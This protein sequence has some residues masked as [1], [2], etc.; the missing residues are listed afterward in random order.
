MDS[1]EIY[2]EK[3][4]DL[5]GDEFDDFCSSMNKVLLKGLRVNLSKISV[6]DFLNIF[7]YDISQVD[8][9]NEGFYIDDCDIK[10]GKTPLYY[11]GLFYLQEP[12]AMLPGV[13]LNVEEDDKILDI[14]AAPGGK[15]TQI[16]SKLGKKGLLVANDIS[17]KRSIALAKNLAYAGGENSIVLNKKPEHLAEMFLN[18]FD[19]ILI[20]APCS[21][22]GLFKK[23]NK[24][25]EDDNSKYASMQK[26]ILIEIPKMLKLDGE[27]VYSTCTFSPE[28]NEKI[29][30]WFLDKYPDFKLIDINIE[31]LSNGR[32]EWAENYRD[33]D[34]TKRAWPHKLK[35][36]GHF[37]ARLK[38]TGRDEE[39][40]KFKHISQL[41]EDEIII[42]E[43][44]VE[45][46]GIDISIY[47]D[48]YDRL[49]RIDDKLYLLPYA[50]NFKVPN[51]F[52][53][54]GILLGE[55][56]KNKFIPDT[57]WALALNAKQCSN[58][59][60]FTED[61]IR[62]TKY[63]KGETITGQTKDGY[64]LV[65][66]EGYGIGFALAKNNVLKNKYK[67]QWRMQ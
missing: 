52:L 44:F 17:P 9:C 43:S 46:I 13:A 23:D 37:I 2:L 19:K 39:N 15:S 35:G 31:G 59:I 30:K 65:T 29:I 42:I 34:K 18:Y 55:F 28:E 4:K 10:L 36:E 41:S 40:K 16:V 33:I 67:K 24:H 1:K 50:M 14:A 5:L 64:C 66:V 53:K 54:C 45:N 62:L 38:R 25:F 57:E 61:D 3:M 51:K 60:S 49:F 48:F 26:S 63:L 8:W 6:N 7:N 11:A 12:S 32:P 56:K 27:I 20:D 47:D 21:G 58:H 22:E